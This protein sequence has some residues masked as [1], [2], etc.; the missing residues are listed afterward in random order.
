MTSDHPRPSRPRTF[1]MAAPIN[2]VPLVQA[3]KRQARRR[4]PHRLAS[5]LAAL[6]RRREGIWWGL[7]IGLALGFVVFGMCG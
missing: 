5:V 3:R 4:Y 6:N 2:I 1:D 7:I